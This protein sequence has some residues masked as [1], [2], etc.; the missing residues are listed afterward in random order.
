MPPRAAARRRARRP[1]ATRGRPAPHAST[2]P[3][4]AASTSAV[5][6]PAAESPSSRPHSSTPRAAAAPAS[7]APPASRLP[8][9]H[10]SQT[11]SSAHVRTRKTQTTGAAWP[12]GAS[13]AQT[14]TGSGLKAGPSR[15]SSP[16]S[17]TSRPHR[18]H[19]HGSYE[20][21]GATTTRES[22]ASAAA[23][24]VARHTPCEASGSGCKAG[25]GGEQA[26]A[27]TLP[28]RSPP[29]CSSAGRP[30]CSRRAGLEGA[31]AA[32]V[33]ATLVDASLRGVDSHGVARTPIY[34]ER[35]RA[36]GINA[37]PQPRIEREAGALA[38]M[39]GDDGPG[40]VAGVLATDHSIELGAALRDRRRRGAAQQPL[41][42]RR[43]LRDARGACG[44]DRL[45]TTNADPLVIPFG[46]RGP[47]ARHEPDRVRRAAA[48]RRVLPRHG[49]EPGR[50]QPRSSTRATRDARS[51][52]AGAST[53]RAAPRRT[54]PPSRPA[55]PLGGYKG[56]GLA[57]M[58]EILS[59]V[60][61]GAG[62][63][64]GV[65]QLYGD[66]RATAGRRP[67]PPRAR[68]RAAR[69]RRLRRAARRRSSPTSRR[70][71]PGPGHDEVLV[72]GDPEERTAAE[73]ARTGIPLTPF[74]WTALCE[75]SAELGV[76]PPDAS[77]GRLTPFRASTLHTT[78]TG[79]RHDRSRHGPVAAGR[80]S[81]ARR[82]RAGTRRVG[83]SGNRQG[84]APK[85]GAAGRRIHMATR[86]RVAPE[87]AQTRPAAGYAPEAPAATCPRS[88]TG[89]SPS[90]RRCAR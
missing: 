50:D 10:A 11:A 23:T 47:G 13:S 56:Y 66:A 64:H 37:R 52:R 85:T 5:S 54:P 53:P 29:P 19:I 26:R 58:V 77:S 25:R 87:R 8:S 32:T 59:G 65:G 31:A 17:A 36:G 16:P 78:S 35:L 21:A 18:S 34:V 49:H 63:A 22:A 38:L 62:V 4:P 27:W 61:T 42:R 7:G 76:E 3:R 74:V 39:D 79:V 70:C 1:T 73:R 88:S 69:R 90:R 40:Q 15:V 28:R 14:A 82:G 67:L 86:T 75:V 80:A 81:G 24:A 57:I 33:A 45:S 2:P 60:L 20:G 89:T 68:S 84:G 46:G 55:F 9:R 48:R 83:P 72:P 41:R 6:A 44:A 30:S 12:S 43:L 51:R 71:P